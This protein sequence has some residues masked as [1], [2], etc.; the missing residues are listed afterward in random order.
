M[1]VRHAERSKPSQPNNFTAFFFPEAVS[2]Q[3]IE[4]HGQLSVRELG[5]MDH[6]ELA[7]AS[8]KP[9]EELLVL[10]FQHI[11]PRWKTVQIVRQTGML[12]IIHDWC[13]DFHSAIFVHFRGD[14]RLNQSLDKTT[15]RV[16][17]DV[18]RVTS[19]LIVGDF[20]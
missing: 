8:G 6:Q 7:E 1:A 20:Q 2:S 16:P 3:L 11:L 13:F 15:F 18:T 19:Q 10:R 14:E 5:I 17:F 12:K 9:E 4:L